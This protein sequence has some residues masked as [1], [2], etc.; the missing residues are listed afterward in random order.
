MSMRDRIKNGQL[1]TDYCEGLPEDRSR[2][3]TILKEFNQTGP[4]ELEKRF[5]LLE[6][7]FD[8]KV[9]AWIEP[10]FYCCYGKNIHLSSKVYVNFNCQF[11]DDGDIFVEEEVM[12]GPGVTIATVSHPIHPDYRGYMY[13]KPVHIEKRV[14]IGANV[15]ILPGVTIGEGSVIGA[16]SVVT[17]SI[18]ANSVAVGNPCR[19]LRAITE[20]DK[21][22]YSPG[23]RIAP[24][25][26]EEE[27]KLR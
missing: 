16:G 7:L 26:L 4:T 22:F 17:K 11:V 24:E 1:F 27:R 10:P 19:V 2:C 15:T 6:Q 12:F 8:Y 18:P 3:K 21:S 23:K 13:T 20:D 25:D 9:E 5:E 14:W